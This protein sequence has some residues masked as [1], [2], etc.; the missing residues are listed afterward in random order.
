MPEIVAI[1][2]VGAFITFLLANFNLYIVHKSFSDPKIKM[3]NQNL[4]RLG[5]YWSTEQGAPVAASTADIETLTEKDYQKSTRSAF[6]FG[7][8]MIFLSWLGLFI[9]STYMISVYKIAKTRTE[10]KVMSSEL[11]SRD[12]HDLVELK[13][14]INQTAG[15]AVE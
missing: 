4:S 6:V 3:L 7:T 9:L 1:G 15:V 5:W 14:L 11:V 8:M 12:I 13:K 2:S 10:K